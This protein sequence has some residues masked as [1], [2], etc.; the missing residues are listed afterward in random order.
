MGVFGGGG[1]FPR[2]RILTRHDP[3]TSPTRSRRTDLHQQQQQQLLQYT[4]IRR[5][6]RQLSRVS[7]APRCMYGKLGRF[8]VS[9]GTLSRLSRRAN[10]TARRFYPSGHLSE[11]IARARTAN[12][13]DAKPITTRLV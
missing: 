2:A 4:H 3:S 12:P 9:S 8:A 10:R 6:F 1:I 13:S 5:A 7:A 11:P